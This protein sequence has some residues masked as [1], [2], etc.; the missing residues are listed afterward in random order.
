[1][2][3]DYHQDIA[4][5]SFA[6]MLNDDERNHAYHVAIRATVNFL[7]NSKENNPNREKHFKCCDIGTGS[8]LLSMMI[9]KSFNEINYNH[10]EVIAFEMFKPM[11]ECAVKIIETNGMSDKIKVVPTRVEDYNQEVSFDLVVAELLDTELIGEG[12]LLT[13]RKVLEKFCSPSCIFIPQEARIYIEPIASRELFNRQFLDDIRIKD[14]KTP[15]GDTLT[16]KLPDEFKNCSGL[17]ALDDVQAS[18]LFPNFKFERFSR[19]KVVFHFR[20]DKL[21]TLKLAETNCVDF[22]VH[23]S[24]NEP[25][26]VVMWW[27]I[28]MYDKLLYAKYSES[29]DQ[30]SEIA[31]AAGHDFSVL[32]CSPCWARDKDMLKR[33]E[34]IRQLYGRDVWREH[35]MQ[36]IYYFRNVKAMKDIRLKRE[37]NVTI[38]AEHD[39]HSLHFDLKPLE[40]G[41]DCNCGV[42][43]T[44]S[45][46][47]IS[48]LND[49]ETISRMVKSLLGVAADSTYES[50]IA[51]NTATFRHPDCKW[52]MSFIES[53][54]TR[55]EQRQF[56]LYDYSLQ[57]EIC[58]L[59]LLDRLSRQESI[60]PFSRF[61]IVCSQIALPNLS[62]IQS[63]VGLCQG[64]NLTEL[65][66]MIKKSSKLCDTNVESHYLWQYD[67]ELLGDEFVIMS[68][69]EFKTEGYSKRVAIPPKEIRAKQTSALVFWARFHLKNIKPEESIISTGLIDLNDK[70]LHTQCIRWSRGF[71]RG[72]NTKFKQLVHFIDSE[73]IQDTVM[74]HID[75]KSIHIR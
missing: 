22:E 15:Q 27:D 50:R 7:V 49:H 61:D 9:V 52:Q 45:R 65:D 19:P 62:R 28:V 23:S 72:W 29:A 56:V 10:F 38:Y 31:S 42:H 60:E 66:K 74:V 71:R 16:I 64:F 40:R 69:D 59:K 53:Q 3:K 34:Y 20:F 58:W 47:E 57:D 17:E 18:E 44:L 67:F 48:F 70:E 36:A 21:E 68:S 4:R 25:P 73:L 24:T 33:D 41:L 46:A 14:F 30:S 2:E 63:T 5:S 32:S 51:F 13:Y 37:Q 11:A 1:M 75:S 6:D 35:W 8:G 54:S 55:L 26:V 12:C 39:T 43:R